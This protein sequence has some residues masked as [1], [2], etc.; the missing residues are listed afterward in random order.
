MTSETRVWGEQSGQQPGSSPMLLLEVVS[1]LSGP[2]ICHASLSVD[3]CEKAVQ[4]R[5]PWAERCTQQII[6]FE[7]APRYSHFA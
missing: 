3:A 2:R 5:H 7:A 6:V 4:Q 1:Y